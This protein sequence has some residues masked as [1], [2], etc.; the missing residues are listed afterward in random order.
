MARALYF[1]YSDI[2]V[3]SHRNRK[4]PKSMARK[5]YPLGIQTFE[6]HDHVFIM[7]LKFDKSANEALEQIEA[8]RYVDAFALSGKKVVK[9]GIALSVKDERNITEWIIR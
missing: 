6:T 1:V 3:Y 4:Q 5:L 9:V 8:K 7:E 2:F